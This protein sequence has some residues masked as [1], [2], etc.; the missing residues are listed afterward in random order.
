[1]TITNPLVSPFDSPDPNPLITPQHAQMIVRWC[2]WILITWVIAVFVASF[3]ARLMG[4]MFVG[5]FGGLAALVVLVVALVMWGVWTGRR[6]KE[7]LVLI[8]CPLLVMSM[9]SMNWPMHLSFAM[10][11]SSL[12]ALAD[13]IAAGQSVSL[14]ASAGAFTICDVEV[15]ADGAGPIVCLWTRRHDSGHVGFVRSPA[16]VTPDVNPWTHTQM[17]LRWHH[18]A[19]D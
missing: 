7:P 13:Q 5:V 12:N 10:S 16:G 14:P 18:F 8:A 4:A 6:W 3:F 15:R 11:Q 19:E 2:Q 1:M 17:N 9:M